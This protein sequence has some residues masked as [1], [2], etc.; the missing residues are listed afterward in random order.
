MQDNNIK[1][2]SLSIQSDLQQ[3]VRHLWIVQAE[4]N[5]GDYF[6]FRTYASTNP[7]LLLVVNGHVEPINT[8]VKGKLLLIGQTN[9]WFRFKATNDFQ[10][11]G[12][13]FFPFAMPLLF[14]LAADTITNKILDH[15]FISQN[16][17]LMEFCKDISMCYLKYESINT[18]LSD[19]VSTIELKD[20]DLLS[21]ITKSSSVD[22]DRE[23]L[24]HKSLFMSQRNF[25][26]KFKHYS[27]FSPK[28][29]TNLIRMKKSFDAISFGQSTLS[30]TAF[31]QSYFDQAHFSN[32][33][34]K[35]TGFQ[36]KVFS[37]HDK[38]HNSIW[39]DFVDFFQFLSICPP[40][41]CKN[42]ISLHP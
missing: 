21:L 26:R 32:E 6:V 2:Q 27:G 25:E 30:D 5:E 4:P 7:T 1:Y 13:T 11:V 42:K 12:I 24:T 14:N 29:F 40:V 3:F 22:L 23:E 15:N 8:Q 19:M 41:L 34:K 36:P 33:F 9:Q 10:L 35:H 18:L 31:E 37:K 39:T 20:E 16:E 28:T 17:R 38:D